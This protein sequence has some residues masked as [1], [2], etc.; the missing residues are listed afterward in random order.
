MWI[1]FARDED[2]VDKVFNS[3]IMSVYRSSDL[4]EIIDEI[5]THMETQIE[6][7]ALLN[8]RFVFDEV[9]YLDVNFHPLNLMR[10]S[11]YLP[12][13]DYIVKRKA[14]INPQNSN[15]ECFKWAI[16][17]V[18]KWVEIDSRPERV[19]NLKEFA[20]NY[21]WSGLEFPV[22]IKGIGK[23]ENNNISVNVL[24]LE[25]DKSI[26][27]LKNSNYNGDREINLL[28]IS[29]N[30][31]NHYTSIKSLSRLNSSS[32][33]KHGHKQYFCTSCLQG[34]S[35]EAS[36]DQHR[37]YCKD[38]EAVG[39]EMPRKGETMEFCDGQNQFKVPFMMY[40]DL[41][42]LLPLQ[43][44]RGQ[45]PTGLYSIKVN[46]YIPCGWNIRSKFAYGEVVDPEKSYRGKNCIKTLCKHLVEEARHLYHM[47]S[48][49]P[50][51]PLTDREWRRHNHSTRYHICFK[52]LV[53]R[54]LR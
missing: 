12:L 18:D 32:N 6:N 11:S 41:E 51:D 53:P 3:K 47:F 36:R 45:D 35:L 2:R 4:E 37:V 27:V 19:A 50:M 21:D 54:I 9:L 14:V 17:A 26:Y 40:Y 20:D 1:R 16:I 29:E 13:P 34:F 44:N 22:S 30:G 38:N 52:S 31:S 10:G 5:F 46:Q 43:P 24:G 28:M 49:K 15:E 8:S 33:S 39:V 25:E 23:F 48:E 42:A 7:P